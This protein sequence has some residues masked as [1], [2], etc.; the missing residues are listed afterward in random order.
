MNNFKTM[1]RVAKDHLEKFNT[2]SGKSGIKF[3][4]AIHRPYSK[5]REQG[6]QDA[7]FISG[8]A[9]GSTAE[10]L[11][12]NITK[13]SRLVVDGA[14]RSD[15]YQ[16]DGQTRYSMPYILIDEVTL[17]DFKNSGQN[18]NVQQP[19][20]NTVSAPPDDWGNSDIPF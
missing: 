9:F 16:K 10:F 6:A 1:V 3:L 5:N 11:E 17:V 8:V 12:R 13:S 20:Q 18:S 7:D 2:K 15:R 4:M 19:S 14:L